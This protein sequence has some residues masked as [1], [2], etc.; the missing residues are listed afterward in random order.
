MGG[1]NVNLLKAKLVERGLNI[2][3]LAK[4]IA[5]DKATL[6]RKLQNNG[7]GLLVKEANDIVQ[8]LNLT[9]QE[10]MEIF[11]AQRVA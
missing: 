6:Y 7:A 4:M 8:A 11:F 1:V 9:V 5:I 10:A 2:T 3:S